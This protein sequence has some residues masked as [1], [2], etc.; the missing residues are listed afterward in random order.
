MRVLWTHNFDPSIPNNLVFVDTTAQ[1][2]SALGVTVEI[3][4]L[5]N[6]RSVSRLLKTRR[7]VRKMA[8]GFDVV[9][10]QYGSACA[11][12]T[13]A[14]THKPKVITIRGSDWN[15][16][17]PSIGPAYFHAGLSRLFT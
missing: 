10:S 12:A 5:G 16:Y 1:A 17:S 15:V 8:E 4:Y 6:L 2:V 7:Q 9:H 14:V 11:L 3:E 13:A